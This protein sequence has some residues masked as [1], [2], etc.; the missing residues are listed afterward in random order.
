MD[1]YHGFVSLKPGA[2]DLDF[3]DSLRAYLDRLKAGN[4]IAGWRLMRRKLGLGPKELKEFHIMIEVEDLAQL[5]R[6]FGAVATRAGGI[7][8]AHHA[9]NSLVAESTFALY[10]DFP[11]SVRV[12]GEERF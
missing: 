5:D 6:A 2:S 3:A 11:D 12:R 10:R 8:L 1:I 4:Q 9:V 7:E